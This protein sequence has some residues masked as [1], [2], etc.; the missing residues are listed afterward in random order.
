MIRTVTITIE[1]SIIFKMSRNDLKKNQDRVKSLRIEYFK[2][3]TWENYYNNL[4][5]GE[6]N[7]IQKHSYKQYFS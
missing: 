4:K 7:F 5:M 2:E 1:V 6:K 3:K